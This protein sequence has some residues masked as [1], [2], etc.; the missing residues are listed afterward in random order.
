MPN[1]DHDGADGLSD[2]LDARAHGERSHNLD[3]ETIDAV[4]RFFASD[5]APP[6]PPDLTR[7]LWEDLMNQTTATAFP[8]SIPLTPRIGAPPS[9][10]GHRP[11]APLRLGTTAGATEASLRRPWL[12]RFATVA[13]LL[14][15]L[16]LGYA[17]FGPIRLGPDQPTS[18][19]AVLAPATPEA[20]IA[21]ADHAIVGVWEQDRAPDFGFH[22]YSYTIFSEDGAYVSYDA[23]F[24]VSIGRWRA[25]DE[26][27]V[28][29]V[30]VIQRVVP[31]ELF[32]PNRV[33]EGTVLEPGREIW[34]L[35]LTLDESGT[36][37]TSVGGFAFV[38]D[39]G[40]PPHSEGP[41]TME[42]TRV[43]AAP[44]ADQGT[45]AA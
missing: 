45:P 4:R 16:A 3:P 33:P 31:Q 38:E 15:T 12:A 13:L 35:V 5:D 8:N 36:T 34:R 40:G 6:P 11:L 14:L 37:M 30:C 19:P 25:T 28:E 42:W 1:A 26:R 27:T 39:D 22:N 9:R 7:Q 41:W 23:S 17:A 29:L 44:G 21:Q 20:P 43:S 32:D 2:Y 18:V 24:G 10:N